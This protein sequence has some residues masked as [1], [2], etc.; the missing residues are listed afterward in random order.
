VPRSGIDAPEIVGLAG[1][2]P[3]RT[4]SHGGSLLV[5]RAAAHTTT[6]GRP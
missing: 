1:L 3:V 2:A 6:S 4:L 5:L